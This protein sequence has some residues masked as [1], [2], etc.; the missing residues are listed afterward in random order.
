MRNSNLHK[1]KTAK[2]DEFYTQIADIEREMVHYRD[3]FKDK[4]VFL[5]CD[6]PEHSNFWKFFE[7]NFTFLG[8]KKLTATHFEFDKPSYK[9]EM[10]EDINGDGVV[11]GMDIIKTPLKQNGD[12]RSDESLDIL[13]ECDIVVTNPPFSIFRE[14]IDVLTTFDKKFLIVGNMNAITYKELFK[15]IKSEKM[16]LG[17]NYAK[18]FMKPDGEIQKFGNILWY[19]NLEHQKRREE[20]ILTQEFNKEKHVTYDNYN[21]IE[22]GRVVNIPSNYSGVMGVPITYLM[23]HNPLKFEIVGNAD[24]DKDLNLV[25]AKMAGVKVNG[26]AKFK[27]LFIKAKGNK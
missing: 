5:N 14:F 11:D 24:N 6:D 2:N 23:K 21:A 18:E 1:A 20:L 22:V 9:L 27:R 15:L 4:H 12:F 7:L 13:A 17:V 8:L 25:T 3:H 26:V 16:W 19:T 10:F